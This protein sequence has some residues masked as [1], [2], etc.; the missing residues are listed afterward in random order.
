MSTPDG[1]AYWRP[2]VSADLDGVVRI[3]RLAFPD[4]FEDRECF[5]ERLSLYPRGCFVLS[6]AHKADIVG[7]L[8]AYPWTNESAPPLNTLIHSIPRNANLLYLHDLALEPEAR[9][10]GHTRTIV[11]DLI[12]QARRDG[13]RRIALVAVNRAERFWQSM[14]FAVRGAESQMQKPDTYGSDAQY[15]SRSI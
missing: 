14:G 8:I 11:A 6:D 12:D 3:A 10:Q 13:W 7:Y 9:G 4:H 2:M 5:A 15:M 1:T